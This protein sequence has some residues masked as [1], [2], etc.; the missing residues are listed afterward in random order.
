MKRIIGKY[1]V[2]FFGLL[3]LAILLIPH[4]VSAASAGDG[5]KNLEFNLFEVIGDIPAA[6]VLET[7]ELIESNWDEN[8]FSSIVISLGETEMLV[9][10]SAEIL[11][12]PAVI[13]GGQIMLPIIDIANAVGADVEIDET[14]GAVTIIN[15]GEETII[16]Q[17]LYDDNP[18]QPAGKGNISGFGYSIAALPMHEKALTDNEKATSDNNKIVS[19]NE[20]AMP[21]KVGQILTVS[22]LLTAAEAEEALF[23]DIH[24]DGDRISI[25]KPYQLKQII[26]Y[27]KNGQE[28]KDN[29]GADQYTSDDQGL[30]FLQYPSEKLTQEAYEVFRSDPQIAYVTVNQVVKNDALSDRWGSERIAADRFKTYLGN[31]NKATTPISV[32]VLDTGIDAT[33]PH[34]QGRTVAGYNFIDSNT[35]PYD[36]NGHGTHVSGTIVDCS[37]ANVKIMPIKIL[38]DNGYGNELEISLGIKHAADNGAKVINM[39]LGSE[40]HDNNCLFK[41]AVDYAVTKDVT[42]VVSAGNNADNA[43][44]YCPAKLANVIT[45]SA[46]DIQD[47]PAYFT[48][49]GA[50]IDVAAPGV[51]ILSS[52][53]DG[54]YEYYSGTSMASPH[55][56]AAVAMLKLNDMNAT[57]AQ[58]KTAVRNTAVPVTGV[59]Q[60]YYGAGLLDFNKF[61]GAIPTEPPGVKLNRHAIDIKTMVTKYRYYQLQARVT[62]LTAPNKSVTYSSSNPQVATCDEDGIVQINNNGTAIITVKAVDG[63]YTDICVVNVDVDESQFWL[64]SAASSFAGGNGTE[65]NPYQIATPQQLALLASNSRYRIEGGGLTADEY[66]ELTA[67]IDLSGKEWISICWSEDLGGGFGVMLAFSG[68]FNGNG[69]IIKNMS[70]GNVFSGMNGAEG[71]LFYWIRGE[72]KDLGIVDVNQKGINSSEFPDWTGI[73]A[74]YTGACVIENCFTSGK[75]VGYSFITQINGNYGPAYYSPTYVPPVFKNCYANTDAQT[76]RGF[77]SGFSGAQVSNCYYYG[78][79]SFCS[80]I[81]AAGNTNKT[82][83]LNSFKAEK[84]LITTYF[85]GN[86]KDSV[87]SKS[88]HAT[89][90]FYGII[91]DDDPSTT[92]L[93]PKPLSFFKDLNSYKNAANWNSQY[94]WDFDKVWSIDENVNDGLPYLK[95]FASAT[96]AETPSII[97][98]P[99]D[100]TVNVGAAATLT[101]EANVSRGALSYQWYENSGKTNYGGSPISGATGASYNAPTA[102]AGTRYYCCMVTNTDIAATGNK[103]VALASSIVSVTVNAVNG[104]TIEWELKP[105]ETNSKNGVINA[106]KDIDKYKFTAPVSGSYTFLTTNKASTLTFL[107]VYLYNSA[108]SL[109]DYRLDGGSGVMFAYNLEAGQTY[110]LDLLGYWGTGAYTINITVPAD[111][112]DNWVLKP[113]ETNSKNGVINAVKQIDRYKFIAPLSNTYTFF[114][115]NKAPTLTYLDAYLYNSAG[116]LLGSVLD[117]GSGVSFTYNIVEGQTYYLDLLGYLGTGAYTINITI[118]STESIPV[119]SV[120][121]DPPAATLS[122]GQTT[123]LIAT[124]LPENATNKDVIWSSSDLSIAEVNASGVVSAK[125]AGECYIFAVNND[126]P[127]NQAYGYCYLTVSAADENWVLTPGE[128]NSKNG[129]IN[130]VKQIDKYS[131]IAPISETYTFFTTNK[132]PTLTYLDAYLYS[133]AGSLIGSMFDYGSGVSFTCDLIAGQAYYLELQGYWGTGAYTINITTSTTVPIPIQSITVTPP[134]AT[135]SV[136]QMAQLSA[137][138]LPENA[139]NKIINWYTSDPSVAEVNAFGVVTAK[140]AGSCYI[141]AANQNYPQNPAFGFCYLTVS[142]I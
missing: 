126:Y 10:G 124:V 134:T 17:P 46:F 119:Q 120:T 71:G 112:G 15:D 40:C 43:M 122:L 3:L 85:I 14:T 106:V 2:L 39:S 90:Y 81:D 92:D 137:T 129:V 36:G 136:G 27:V 5:E 35:N 93:S 57:P 141:S 76:G 31:N 62:P 20:K 66:F 107:D 6:F 70:Q 44:N 89:D 139:T 91:S 59:A 16:E 135:F 127:Q 109:L 113:G 79:G 101:V 52:V 121:V 11:S 98:Q 7:T 56:A 26:L 132:A 110:Y 104:G 30:Y 1:R 45:V 37:T 69:H 80:Y 105:G 94:P 99:M 67:D 95:I 97:T 88:Y 84:G 63:G 82:Y 116:S 22:P 86:K 83:L 4:G 55:V 131:F 21:F 34:L 51:D 77:A 18:I 8:Y 111:I 32:A 54:G 114:I 47:L 61:F 53:P 13:D 29:Y 28:L 72:I 50:A 24:V 74:T 138:I 128:T 65:A 133:S 142:D 19:D 58:L 9:D 103:T 115:T 75:T 33:H 96:D 38:D 118:P 60:S 130:T 25:S 117:Y 78:F 125:G 73:M 41:Q 123:V 68:H 48:N 108:N 102:A 49:F 140:G 23:L 12:N 87:I 64:G 100:L 42:T